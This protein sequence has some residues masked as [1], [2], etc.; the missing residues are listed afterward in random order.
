MTLG[1][2]IACEAKYRIL[3]LGSTPGDG[4]NESSIHISK[5]RFT[6]TIMKLKL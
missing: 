4:L 3:P 5:G 6:M 1:I 2:G